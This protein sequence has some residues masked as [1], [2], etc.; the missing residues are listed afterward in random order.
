MYCNVINIILIL[1][2]INVIISFE[3]QITENEPIFEESQYGEN[4][5]NMKMDEE[6]LL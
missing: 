3:I 1:L 6:S 5:E 2:F 4:F